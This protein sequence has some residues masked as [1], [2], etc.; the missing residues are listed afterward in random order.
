MPQ[1]HTTKSSSSK[2]R[3]LQ[4]GGSDRPTKQSKKITSYFQ[5][6]YRV[7]SGLKEDE[8]EPV[9]LNGEQRKV[10]EMV[11]DEGKNIFF[12]GAAGA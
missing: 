1:A 5:P 11:V 6:L 10:L 2:K 8:S 3:K 7:P 12:T 9:P 4:V